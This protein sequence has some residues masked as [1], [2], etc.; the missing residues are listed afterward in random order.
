MANYMV[1]SMSSDKTI[2]ITY[3][4][5]QSQPHVTHQESEAFTRDAIDNYAEFNHLELNQVV[6]GHYRSSQ[7]VPTSGKVYEI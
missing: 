4:R 2:P 6:A 1:Q 7:G 5:K 3:Y